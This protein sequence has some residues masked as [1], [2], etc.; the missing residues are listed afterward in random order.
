MQKE[1]PLEELNI[2][3]K[4]KKIISRDDDNT[5]I[6]IISKVKLWEVD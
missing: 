6:Y 1:I 4:H 3:V 5:L 2:L